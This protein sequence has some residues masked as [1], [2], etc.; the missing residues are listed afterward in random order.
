MLLS[1]EQV[2]KLPEGMRDIIFD[3]AANRRLIEKKLTE[4]YENA[5][6]G[7][8]ITPVLEYGE[9]FSEAVLSMGLKEMYK[10]SD[11]SGALTVLRADNTMPM[12]RVAATKLQSEA[13][14]LKLYYNQDIY[15]QQRAFGTP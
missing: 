4:V 9:V 13:L 7:E 14:P 3:E 10:L 8:V 11:M 2:I 6:Y 12:A 5:G 1:A 15:R